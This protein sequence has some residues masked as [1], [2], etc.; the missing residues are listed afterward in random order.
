M[1]LSGEAKKIAADVLAD[2]EA[3]GNTIGPELRDRAASCAEMATQLYLNELA[4]VEQEQE[5][6]IVGAR[7]QALK[8]AGASAVASAI[9][10]N[11]RNA[12]LKG[13]GVLLKL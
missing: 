2:V 7:F 1:E 5:L 10:D 4:G 11:L 3:R 12:V 9:V 6:A 13:I 8:A